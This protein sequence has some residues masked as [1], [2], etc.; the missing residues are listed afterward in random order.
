MIQAKEH[1]GYRTTA[2]TVLKYETLAM[3]C[4]SSTLVGC[5]IEILKLIFSYPIGHSTSMTE[6]G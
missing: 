3:D 5:I 6:M 4:T 1:N 2:E